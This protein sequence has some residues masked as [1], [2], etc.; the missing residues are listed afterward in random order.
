MRPGHPNGPSQEPVKH[1]VLKDAGITG[2]RFHDLR[3]HAASRLV[4]TG[5]DLY[6]VSEILG[7]QSMTMTK[8]YAHLRDADKAAAVARIA[9]R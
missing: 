9:T 4:Q 8:R 3:H 6:V 7:H 2:F 1:R 5:T